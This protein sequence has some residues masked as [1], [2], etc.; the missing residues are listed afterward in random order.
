MFT[1]D[2]TSPILG[3]FLVFH[4]VLELLEMRLVCKFVIRAHTAMRIMITAPKPVLCADLVNTQIWST[5]LLVKHAKV[6]YRF[7][8][9]VIH[10]ISERV[11]E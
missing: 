10:H 6:F 1:K 8:A 4:V 3:K 5:V 11:V 7:L 2:T 9:F